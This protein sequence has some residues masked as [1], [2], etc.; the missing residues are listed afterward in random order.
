[1]SVRTVLRA[2][3][4]LSGYDPLASPLAQLPKRSHNT[5]AMTARKAI[6]PSPAHPNAC[7]DS[8]PRIFLRLS[9]L[10][11]AA[12]QDRI[13]VKDQS[14]ILCCLTANRNQKSRV[15]LLAWPVALEFVQQEA[16]VERS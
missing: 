11:F 4:P 7:D 3:G 9:R 15:C 1:M 5:S 12:V 13:E 14:L 10:D 8:V 2:D 16:A 6:S